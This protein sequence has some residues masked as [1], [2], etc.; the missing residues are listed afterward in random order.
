M[1]IKLDHPQFYY[2]LFY[3]LSS[4][5]VILIFLV[6][7]YKR[8]IPLITMLLVVVTTRFFL[9]VGSKL[10]GINLDV[11]NYF[12]QHLTFPVN[13]SR[14]MAGALLFALLGLGIA[15]LLLRIK[16]PILDVFAMAAPFGM[17]IQRIGCLLTGCCFGNETNLPIGIQYGSNTPAFMHEFLS[18]RLGIEDKL[19][20]HIHPVP[21][22]IVFYSLGVG[23]LML[24][25]RN[26][27]KRPGNLALSCLLLILAGWFIIEF[28]RDPLSNG[29][30]LG[31]TVMG[32]K[33]IQVIYLLL[34]PILAA[35]IYYRE[36]QYVNKEFHSQENHPFHNALYLLMLVILLVITRNW[37]S[38][39][40]FNILLYVL[41][42]VTGGIIIQLIRHLY[43]LQVRIS[44]AFLIVL[45]FILMSQTMPVKE[46]KVYQSVKIGLANGS[47]DTEHNIG[48]G[49]GCDRVS[50][51]QEFHQKYK[52]MGV[53][54]SIT[55]MQN[56]EVLEYG[57]N[58]YFGQH[59]ELGKTTLNLTDHQIISINPF[60][61]YDLN[62]LG[63]GGGF[64]IGNLRYSP[65]NWSEDNSVVQLPV[66]GT[67]ESPVLP[68]FYFRVGPRKWAF[69]SY[70]Y[71]DQF[72]SPFPG[73]YSHL[74]FGTGLGA[75]SGFNLRIGT[76]GQ[77]KSY[78]TGY[79]P[80][81]DL[82]V[83][84]PFYGWVNSGD[85]GSS[86]QNQF[87]LGI[88]YRFAHKTKA[89]QPKP[90]PGVN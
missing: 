74:E 79:I 85:F 50:Q 2:D 68:Q 6:E 25:Y 32:L 60:V 24:T 54:Y 29:T 4:L 73:N 82:F 62:W 55:E 22:Y 51:T 28:F 5:I 34:I 33:R 3:Q 19:S 71:A 63:I 12:Y 14:N 43:S 88:H 36:K 59:T 53:G 30:F 76:D 80:I 39:T 13:H 84:E 37:F 75:K 47:F 38:V 52:M 15:K 58:G 56:K 90:I 42:P 41:I 86:V 65:V 87:S 81:H 31:A 72:P 64:H 1:I 18:G 67:K 10:G 35:T 70:K 40:E 9:I 11:L 78:L 45:S 8:K 21:L 27:W 17:A 48:M 23:I 57:L 83:I 16:Y 20:L 49:E 89:V 77:D 66:T 46:K 61:K 26:F 7:S 69:I 44:V